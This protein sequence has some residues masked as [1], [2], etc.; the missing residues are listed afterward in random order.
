MTKMFTQ[1]Y[2]GDMPEREKSTFN[3]GSTLIIW[4]RKFK[5]ISN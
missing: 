3:I 5:K 4:S 1:D 2:A